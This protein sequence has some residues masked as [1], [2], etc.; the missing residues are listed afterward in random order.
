MEPIDVVGWIF[1]VVF[2]VACLGPVLAL[3]FLPELDNNE[4]EHHD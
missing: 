2:V 4:G 3:L 1:I